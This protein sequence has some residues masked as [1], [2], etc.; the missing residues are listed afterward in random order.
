MIYT[1]NKPLT[2]SLQPPNNAVLLSE[3][4]LF[5][6]WSLGQ[7]DS[8]VSGTQMFFPSPESGKPMGNPV[9]HIN[10]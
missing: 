1:L 4:F 2:G 3:S 5:D 9:V 6:L 10:V 7:K 8:L